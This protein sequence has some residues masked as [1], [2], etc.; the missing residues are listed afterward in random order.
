MLRVSLCYQQW[1]AQFK[2]A[3]R[4]LTEVH[5]APVSFVMSNCQCTGDLI[6]EMF[7]TDLFVIFIAF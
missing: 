3:A 4:G 7:V 5:N 1:S 6:L 2:T